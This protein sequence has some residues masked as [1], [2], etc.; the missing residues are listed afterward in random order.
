MLRSLRCGW[1]GNEAGYGIHCFLDVVV[2]R[3]LASFHHDVRRTHR[4]RQ[5]ASE[6]AGVHC[7]GNVFV[8][9]GHQH[10]CSRFSHVADDCFK[11]I[12]GEVGRKHVIV[13]AFAS[14]REISLRADWRAILLRF[15]R[16][17]LQPFS[18]CDHPLRPFHI[19]FCAWQ[20]VKELP[21]AHRR[22][23]HN[24]RRPGD[25]SARTCCQV[26]EANRVL[27][28]RRVADNAERGGVHFLAKKPGERCNLI[29]VLVEA[30]RPVALVGGTQQS[31][32]E[33]PPVPVQTFCERLDVLARE[34]TVCQPAHHDRMLPVRTRFEGDVRRTRAI[35]EKRPLHRMHRPRSSTL[36]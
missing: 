7:H 35:L 18:F 14:K 36:A 17:E 33:G 13:A 3:V 28:T 6:V 31:L 16:H 5:L 25:L 11:L 10:Q 30:A 15:P 23:K 27:A 2:Q 1:L 20:D 32:H 19:P 9:T 22:L 29:G 21:V 26:H 8:A 4:L 24:A 34:Q 12:C